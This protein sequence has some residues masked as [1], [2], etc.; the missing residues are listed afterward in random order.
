MRHNLSMPHDV[1]PSR[2][3]LPT[4]PP[5]ALG[6]GAWLREIREAFAALP[7]ARRRADVE[8]TYP[9]HTLEDAAHLGRDLVAA[10]HDTASI[11]LTP[12]G[13]KLTVRL[14]GAS[15]ARQDA[16]P[17]CAARHKFRPLEMG[18]HPLA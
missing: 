15:I 18:R 9:L 12:G 3:P 7:S 8:R 4:P 17:E 13:G 5:S 11:A 1:P 16:T 2:H 14:A 6:A 10:M